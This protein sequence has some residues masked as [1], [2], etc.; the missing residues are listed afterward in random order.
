VSNHAKA[1]YLNE[2]EAYCAAACAG[3]TF[4]TL[5]SSA[6]FLL[7]K[8]FS[9]VQRGSQIT[10]DCG[11]VIDAKEK[12]CSRNSSHRA[13]NNRL[14]DPT[15]LAK[16][17]HAKNHN[18]FVSPINVPTANTVIHVCDDSPDEVQVQGVYCTIKDDDDSSLLDKKPSADQTKDD[19]INDRSHAMTIR[20]LKKMRT[21]CTSGVSKF[22]S[23]STPEKRKLKDLKESIAVLTKEYENGSHLHTIR[24]LTN[25]GDTLDGDDAIDSQNMMDLVMSDH[26]LAKM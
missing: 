4:P 21:Q 22:S 5:S 15:S 14:H 13:T 23:M 6:H 2:T 26:E 19:V 8:R 3:E 1:G 10:L 9:D 24:R 18:Q 11:T 7:Q 17:I 25:D 20:T 12:L 16:S